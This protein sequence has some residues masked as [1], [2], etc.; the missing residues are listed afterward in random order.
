MTT[1]RK[2]PEMDE[3][4]SLVD[5]LTRQRAN[6]ENHGFEFVGSGTSENE[7]TLTACE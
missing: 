1:P 5:Q 3:F 7:R 6:I 2:H 4:M